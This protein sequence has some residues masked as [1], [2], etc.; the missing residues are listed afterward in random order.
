MID[1][2]T[3]FYALIRSGLFWSRH[4][5]NT[6]DDTFYD[7]LDSCCKSFVFH[8][9]KT[10]QSPIS[11]GGQMF[12]FHEKEEEE[13]EEEEEEGGEDLLITLSRRLVIAVVSLW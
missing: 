13:E 6:F 1:K 11:F 4:L 12:R 2:Q 3:R 7:S 5:V 9:T 8:N 10:Y